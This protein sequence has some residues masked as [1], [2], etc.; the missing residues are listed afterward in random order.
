MKA[1]EI[2]QARAL[3]PPP[4]PPPPRNRMEAFH[5]PPLSPLHGSPLSCSSSRPA[6]IGVLQGSGRGGCIV[7][8]AVPSSSSFHSSPNIIKSSRFSPYQR[9]ANGYGEDS[10]E[11][12]DDGE[13]EEESDS[14]YS[15][16]VSLH[17]FRRIF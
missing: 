17:D 8:F 5:R 10:E 3:S 9:R 15:S 1:E 7:A 4:P 2:F 11:E 6:A 16:D 14:E 12:E 13:E